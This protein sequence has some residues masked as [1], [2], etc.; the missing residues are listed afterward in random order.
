MCSVFIV[1][2]HAKRYTHLH[3][4]TCI[5][6]NV[7]ISWCTTIFMITYWKIKWNGVYLIHVVD[8]GFSHFDLWRFDTDHSVYIV[9]PHGKLC[10]LKRQKLPFM[11][12]VILHPSNHVQMTPAA[13]CGYGRSLFNCLHCVNT[14][15]I[16]FLSFLCYLWHEWPQF[17]HFLVFLRT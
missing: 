8:P 17:L 4:P 5:H 7:Y 12:F 16:S 6:V 9:F 10:I 1:W 2:K 14:I 13:K 3:M 15:E 11:K